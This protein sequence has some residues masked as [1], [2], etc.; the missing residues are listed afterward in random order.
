MP[1]WGRGGHVTGVLAAGLLL[2]GLLPQQ[3]A[4]AT[5]PNGEVVAATIVN[6]PVDTTWSAKLTEK[7]GTTHYARDAA[8]VE[9]GTSG[10]P[11][12]GIGTVLTGLNRTGRPLC[13]TTNAADAQGFCWDTADD[14]ATGYTHVAQGLTGSGEAP[15]NDK[16]VGGR[17]IVV[18]GWYPKAAGGAIRVTFAD[19]TDPARVKYRHVALVKPTATGYTALTGHAHS[20]TWYNDRLYLSTGAGMALFDLNRFWDT[21]PGGTAFGVSNGTPYTPG[22][23]YALPLLDEFRYADHPAGSCGTYA[24]TPAPPCF[25]GAS[26]DLSGPEP[27]LVT[28]ELNGVQAKQQQR[29]LDPGVILRWPL[30]ATTGLPRTAKET[31]GQNPAVEVERARPSDAYTSTVSGAQG[32]AMNR[33][34]FVVSAPCPEFVEGG[35]NI[36]SCLYHAWPGEPVRLWTRTGVNNENV[37]YWPATD[38]LW[39]INEAPGN[40]TVFHIR[41]PRP[42]LPVRSLTG[43]GGS[44]TGSTLPDV[45]AIRPKASASAGQGTGNLVLYPGAEGGVGARSSIGS[46]WDSMRLIAGVGNLDADPRPDVLAVDDGGALWLYPGAANGLGGR[47]PVSATGWGVVTRMTG[48]GNMTG[49]AHPDLLAIWAN[50]DAYLYEGRAGGP[51]PSHKIGTSWNTMR[52]MTG[53]GDL[54][55]DGRPDV[56]AVDDAEEKLWLYPGDASGGLG[57]RKEVSTGWGIVRTMAGVGDLTGDGLPDVLAVWEDGTAR[58]YPGRLDGLGASKPVDLGWGAR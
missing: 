24:D 39:T 33:G 9:N 31:T 56:L 23:E 16:L 38:E 58:L 28:V 45:I 4:A 40:L 21:D 50:G 1:R 3:A 10:V 54:T 11:K 47:T 26:L 49:D 14:A 41:W 2:V 6:R 55:G 51:G 46:S 12:V 22:Y 44:L 37:S 5:V 52:L 25:T 53:A 36:P 27:A 7:D 57:A 32:I 42:E 48:V 30:D 19:V 17:Q 35:D 20:L 18:A 29:F 15:E 43:L 8:A 13:H 34:R